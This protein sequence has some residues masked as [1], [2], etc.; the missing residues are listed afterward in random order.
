MT[1]TDVALTQ[2]PQISEMTKDEVIRHFQWFNY[3]DEQG[4]PLTNNVDFIQLIDMA[5]DNSVR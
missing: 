2:F 1:Q 4:H 5:F 3:R